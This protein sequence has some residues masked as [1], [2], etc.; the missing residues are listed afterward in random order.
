MILNKKII[1]VTGAAGFIG[2][3]ISQK[4]LLENYEVIGIDNINGYYNPF[5]KQHRIKDIEQIDKNNCWR[6]LKVNLENS[7]K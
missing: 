4:L 5:L 3:A 7:K 1:L 6:F 2:S